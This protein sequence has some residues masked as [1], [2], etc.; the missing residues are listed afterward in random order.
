[1]VGSGL[2]TVTV[3]GCAG[4][5]ALLLIDPAAKLNPVVSAC[6]VVDT[7]LLTIGEVKEREVLG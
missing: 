3:A 7:Y 1:M 2:A 5:G 6:V 4:E